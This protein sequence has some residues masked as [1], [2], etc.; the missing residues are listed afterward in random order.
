MNPG[1]GSRGGMKIQEISPIFN[2]R[3]NSQL[4]VPDRGFGMRRL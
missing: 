4:N 1:L 2:G 3:I